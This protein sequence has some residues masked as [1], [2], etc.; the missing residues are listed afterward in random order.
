MTK[1][2]FNNKDLLE[3][4]ISI[5]DNLKLYNDFK[6]NP[7]DDS[8]NP[9]LPFI[10]SKKINLIIIG[11]DPTIKNYNARRKIRITLN[12]DRKGALTKYVQKICNL[13]NISEENIYATNIFK[14]FYSIPPAKTINIL[15]AH[16][17]E[18][19]NLLLKEISLFNDIP[20]I[21]FGLPVLKLLVQC[22]SEISEYWDYNKKTKNSN[23][24]YKSCLGFQNKLRKE[25]FPFPHLPALRIPFY[26]N[27]LNHYVNFMKLKI[28]VNRLK[29]YEEYIKV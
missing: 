20:I 10:G 3:E 15:L 1:F 28:I 19:L 14:Y 18:N 12:L 13:M 16:L 24:N 29:H 9:I 27:H 22:N 5:R 23:G 11:Q 21:T 8:L 6:Q 7:I 4:S 17:N 25:I 2:F 26:S